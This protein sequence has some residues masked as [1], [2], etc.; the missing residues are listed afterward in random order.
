MDHQTQLNSVVDDL[1]RAANSIDK[2]MVVLNSIKS[3]NKQVLRG[4][5]EIGKSVDVL[6]SKI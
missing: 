6:L 4:V 3:D 1:T 2:L 5:H